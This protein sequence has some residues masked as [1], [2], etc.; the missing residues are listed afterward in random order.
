[1]TSPNE[2]RTNS[3]QQRPPQRRGL[4]AGVALALT[5]L[6]LAAL[7]FGAVHGR[8]PGI[9]AAPTPP[10]NWYTYR[11]PQ[12]FFILSLPNGW[13]MHQDISTGQEG[14]ASGSDAITDYMNAFGSPPF[15][16]NSITVW[17]SVM[18]MVPALKRNLACSPNRPP[19]NATIAG[20]PAWHDD[21]VGWLLDTNAAHFQISYR[22]PNDRGNVARRSSDPTATPMPPGFYERG[23]QDLRTML[24]SFTPTPATP[25]VCNLP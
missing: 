2:E 9:G 19:F 15:G 11:D 14:D 16:T 8:S 7:V 17:V 1:M 23:Q 5:T 12:G 21:L 24:A 10:E 6:L 25:L 18:P 3:E 13:T 22:Y 20:L 4:L